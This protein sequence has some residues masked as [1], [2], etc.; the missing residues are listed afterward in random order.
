MT[1]M[2]A[3]LPFLLL[4]GCEDNHEVTRL[5]Q[6]VLHLRNENETM[7]E[8]LPSER[9]MVLKEL[10]EARAKIVE[11]QRSINILEFN[12]NSKDSETPK[13]MASFV[14]MMRDLSNRLQTLE[15]TASRKGHTH[16]YRDAAPA[17]TFMS[18]TRS[19]EADK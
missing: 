6:E 2:M 9:P 8:S 12:L 19:T 7:K 13:E 16:E 17:G 3:F 1:R 4:V 5:R 18:S 10:E 14:K 15:Q 11:L